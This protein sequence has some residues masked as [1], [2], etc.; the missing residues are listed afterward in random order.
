M[1]WEGGG[2]GEGG[3][4]CQNRTEI[5]TPQGPQGTPGS[6]EVAPVRTGSGRIRAGFR[7]LL[8]YFRGLFA[9]SEASLLLRGLRLWSVTWTGIGD[10][11]R[12]RGPSLEFRIAPQ[13]PRSTVQCL[14]NSVPAKTRAT[15]SRLCPSYIQHIRLT[16]PHAFHIHFS[17]RGVVVLGVL[18]GIPRE[19]SSIPRTYRSAF[20]EF[21]VCQRASV[22]TRNL[23]AQIRDT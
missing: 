8:C 9:N 23:Y 12:G 11:D 18:I 16:V 21:W 4:R 17:R 19:V 20:H 22:N 2:G 13:N 14:R 10:L 3:R 6:P 1:G 15:F 7:L 5:C